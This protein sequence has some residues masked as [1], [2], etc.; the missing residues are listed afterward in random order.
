MRVPC[1]V[2]CMAVSLLT[3]Q[4]L[5]GQL[6]SDAFCKEVENIAATPYSPAYWYH[7]IAFSNDCSLEFD[8][9]FKGGVGIKFQIER[10][11]SKH[12]AEKSFQSDVE[13]FSNAVFDHQ[14]R[15]VTRR[16]ESP[17][18]SFWNRAIFFDSKLLLLRKE[19]SVVTIFCDKRSHCE[20][21]EQRLRS[22]EDLVIF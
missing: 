7:N 10:F 11:A 19:R 20:N 17:R 8:I 5:R 14:G 2:F 15:I 16:K 22:R 6:V 9:D 4:V 21:I 1:L 12:E 18:H 13:M 3:A